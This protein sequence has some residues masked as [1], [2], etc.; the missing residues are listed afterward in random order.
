MIIFESP[1]NNSWGFCFYGKP[2]SE[3][4]NLYIV[5]TS[6]LL[7]TLKN[8]TFL[9]LVKLQIHRLLSSIYRVNF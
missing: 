7:I 9:I 2:L 1:E 5:Y 8:L 3:I 6:L 4:F